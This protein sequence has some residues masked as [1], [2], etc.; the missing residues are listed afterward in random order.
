MRIENRIPKFYVISETKIN[1]QN[2]SSAL[3]D[4][5]FT[6]FD[7]NWKEK[8]KGV[9]VSDVEKLPECLVKF[10]VKTD[11][12][13][14]NQDVNLGLSNNE[15]VFL[16][17]SFISVLFKDISYEFTTVISSDNIKNYKILKS[18]V[19]VD[20]ISFWVP[21][22]IEVSKAAMIDFGLTFDDIKKRIEIIISEF[23]KLGKT[24]EELSMLKEKL[25]ILFPKAVQLDA[26]ISNSVYEWREMILRFTQPN[27]S[28]EER[29]LFLSILRDFKRRY[30]SSFQDLTLQNIRTGEFFG[31]DSL[32][33]GDKAWN[34]FRAVKQRS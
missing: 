25:G 32:D 4:F 7:K 9:R 6:T 5:G 12:G 2:L 22:E 29:F 10:I 19:N 15:S 3:M 33:S 1:E 31:V 34:N 11:H 23:A 16:Q 27:R 28:D 26:V 24:E 18:S 21:A 17:H 14:N 13:L 8:N 20:K 30:P